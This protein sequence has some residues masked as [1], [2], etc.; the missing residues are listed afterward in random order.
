MRFV[1]VIVAMIFALSATASIYGQGRGQGQA[2]KTA[3]SAPKAKSTHSPKQTTKRT[4]K[5]ETRAAR[6]EARAA[7]NTTKAETRAAKAETR[8]TKTG[9]KSAKLNPEQEARLLAKLPAGMTVEQASQGFK[10]WGQ[11]QAAVN[12]SANHNIPFDQLKAK[13]TGIAPGDT[14]PTTAPMSL[15]QALQ[16]FGVTETTPQ[17]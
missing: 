2:K 8:A 16:S 13:M 9:T 14:V 12:A 7:K 1:T 4:T 3:V 17:P 6:A 15:G 11:F 10:N 5:T